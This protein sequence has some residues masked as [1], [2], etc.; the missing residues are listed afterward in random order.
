MGKIAGYIVLAFVA[1]VGIYELST[2]NNVSDVIAES[3][4]KTRIEMATRKA[5]EKAVE[6]RQADEGDYDMDDYSVPEPSDSP[7]STPQEDDNDG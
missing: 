5:N 4:R 7:E 1:L 6:E 2:L 3:N